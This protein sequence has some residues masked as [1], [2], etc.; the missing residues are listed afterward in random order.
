MFV[1]PQGKCLRNLAQIY[2]VYEAI[3]LWDYATAEWRVAATLLQ[4]SKVNT[5]SDSCMSTRPAI[6]LH[7]YSS[8][9]LTHCQL[10]VFSFS[11]VASCCWRV[12]KS[13][14]QNSN[15]NSN[16]NNYS[17]CYNYS[18]SSNS[19]GSNCNLSGAVGHPK[20]AFCAHKLPM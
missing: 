12:G 20:E 10:Q 7:F 5:R 4:S 6:S 17:N 16:S 15:N 19:S 14:Q 13:C 2:G 9:F 11:P 1:F 3:W 18:S 8:H